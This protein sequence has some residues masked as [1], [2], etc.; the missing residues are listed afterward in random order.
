MRDIQCTSNIKEININ[1]KIYANPM[2]WCKI[3]ASVHRKKIN[4]S[5]QNVNSKN[6]HRVFYL[7]ASNKQAT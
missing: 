7:K 5:L 1:N 3:D 6:K 2:H 4:Q